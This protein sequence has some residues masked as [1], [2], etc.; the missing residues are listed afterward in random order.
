MSNSRR[1]GTGNDKPLNRRMLTLAREKGILRAKDADEAGIPRVVLTRLCRNGRL[2][3]LSRGLYAPASGEVTEHH[4]LAE[5]SKKI[6]NAVICLLSAL[7]FHGLTTQAPF[8]VWI[9]VDRKARKPHLSNIPLRVV[10][11]SRVMRTFGVETQ[12]IEKV[13]VRITTAAKTVADCFR[14]RNKIGLD[15]ALEALRDYRRLR[16]SG[17]ELWRAA[18]ACREVSVMR[19][20][21][22]ATV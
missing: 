21:L 1:Y 19:P 18:R 6:P 12:I 5:V 22:E 3:R 2:T 7:R 4:L 20:Y 16:K 13:P 10:R 17:D 8:E 9:A 11:F 15:V 14:Y